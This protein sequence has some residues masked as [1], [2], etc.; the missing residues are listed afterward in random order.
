MFWSNPTSKKGGIGDPPLP[1]PLP[2]RERGGWR[3]ELYGSDKDGDPARDDLS[4]LFQKPPPRVRDEGENIFVQAETPDCFRKNDID[5]FREGDLGGEGLE[6]NDLVRHA[7]PFSLSC[8][9]MNDRID[10][11]GRDA[12]GPGAKG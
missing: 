5:L 3:G 12:G 7:Q 11:A 8:G 4:P 10:I 2:L 9:S 1:G 6:K